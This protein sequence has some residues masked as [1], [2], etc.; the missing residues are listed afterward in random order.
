MTHHEQR[1]HTLARTIHQSLI[2]L[3]TDQERAEGRR[4]KVSSLNYHL[5]GDVRIL[6]TLEGWRCYAVQK[7]HKSPNALPEYYLEFWPR[8]T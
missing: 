3:W 1:V 5:M 6:F 8:E 4:I 2:G 7:G